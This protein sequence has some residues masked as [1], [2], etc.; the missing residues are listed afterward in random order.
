MTRYKV[1]G[2]YQKKSHASLSKFLVDH[3][4]PPLKVDG[5]VK[6]EAIGWVRPLINDE[7]LAIT[8]GA[9]WDMSDCALG[10]D[11]LLRVRYERRK[12]PQSLAQML[13]QQKL[14]SHLTKTGKGMNRQEKIEMKNEILTGLM[15]RTLPVLQ[16]TDV[17]WREAAQEL[18]IF[19]TSKSTRGRIEQLFH[20]TFGSELE[21]SLLKIDGP[22]TY[23]N[24]EDANDN[25]LTRK[26]TK[27]ANIQPAVFS[28]I[29]Q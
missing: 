16:F 25:Q 19:S 1:I 17:L 7:D 29:A 15:K 6:P 10:K 22:L 26:L 20:Q 24:D 12:V 9:E 4:A 28:S 21:L 11:Y 14:R 27:I 5:P 18:I 13:I 8:E 3:K 23:L 2:P